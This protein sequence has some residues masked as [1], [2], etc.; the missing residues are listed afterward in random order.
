MAR[1][2]SKTTHRQALIIA[3]LVFAGMGLKPLTSHAEEVQTLNVEGMT[4]YGQRE[5]PKVMYIV[6]WKKMD[7]ADIDKPMTGSLV[8]DVLDT[9][10]PDLFQRQVRYHDLMQNMV[11]SPAR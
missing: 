6:P 3:I 11:T 5:L 4:I 9:L 2:Y 1:R 10:N 8:A 7:T